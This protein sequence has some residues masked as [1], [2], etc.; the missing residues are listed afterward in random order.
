[1]SN[2]EKERFKSLVEK[3][4]KYARYVVEYIEMKAMLSLL[5]YMDI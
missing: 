3:H 1:M 5:L 4:K 2:K